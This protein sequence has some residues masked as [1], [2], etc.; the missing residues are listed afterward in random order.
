MDLSLEGVLIQQGA[1]FL[2]D[3]RAA[4][5]AHGLNEPSAQQFNKAYEHALSYEQELG[6]ALAAKEQA[7]I[8]LYKADIETLEKSLLCWQRLKI[9]QGCK[10]GWQ[11][12][13]GA[14]I[15]PVPY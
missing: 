13:S 14:A 9:I 12:P 5:V 15:C 8:K 10:Q 7:T 2:S 4:L 3:T 1:Y 6:K 11:R